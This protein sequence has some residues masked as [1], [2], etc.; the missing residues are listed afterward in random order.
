MGNIPTQQA[1]GI[2]TQAYMTAFKEM[3]PASSFLKSFFTVETFDTKFVG[4]EVQR[5]TERIAV[6][7]I[8]GADG[9]RNQFSKSSEKI[10]M[11][12]FYNE[13]FDATSLERYD[14]GFNMA[15]GVSLPTIGYLARDVANKYTALRMKIERAKEKQCAEVFETGIITLNNGDNIDFKRKSGSK[16]DLSGAYWS[17]ITADVES[18]LIN[19]A[20]FIRQTGKNG[21]PE[22]ILVMSGAAWVALKKTNYFKNNANFQKVQL[23]DIQMPQA[24]AFGAAYH[25]RIIA[26]AYTINVWTYDE[27]YE[28]HSDGSITRYLPSNKAFMVPARGTRFNVVHAGVPAI[29]RDLANAEFPEYITQQAAEYYLNNYIDPRG[30][31]HIFE[32]YSAPLAVPV[33]VDQI[34]TMQ[35]LGDSGQTQG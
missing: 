30:K 1:R 29:M 13:N 18:Q 10:Y 19:G 24:S 23:I 5:G 17:D 15:E 14:R 21:E 8:R 6:N 28:A 26:G 20:E 7:V 34:Y 2:F 12:P 3:V 33:T 16:V 25:G 4:I 9:Q 11:P 35:V 22:L 32:I 31:A 27:V